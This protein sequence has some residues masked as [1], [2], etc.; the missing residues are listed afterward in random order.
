MENKAL[1]LETEWEPVFDRRVAHTD[2]PTA[3]LE[4]FHINREH[5]RRE[6]LVRKAIWC[7]M[8]TIFFVLLFFYDL[9]TGWLA[10]PMAAVFA[11]ICSA[12]V[13]RVLESSGK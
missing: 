2:S 1:D 3:N 7:F 8:A 9:L 10:I 11:C 5:R 6:A 13:G 4:R 12:L